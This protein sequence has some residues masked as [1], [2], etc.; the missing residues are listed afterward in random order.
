LDLSLASSI[1]GTGTATQAMKPIAAPMVGGLVPRTLLILIVLPA[2]DPLW[3]SFELR[4]KPGSA[5]GS[6]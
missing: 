5:T 3:K 2:I 6:G 4:G 1:F